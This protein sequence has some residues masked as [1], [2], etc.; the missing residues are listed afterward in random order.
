VG[1]DLIKAQ[2][3]NSPMEIKWPFRS[4]KA[5]DDWEGREFIL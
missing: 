4:S 3:E 5:V 1:D 2:Q